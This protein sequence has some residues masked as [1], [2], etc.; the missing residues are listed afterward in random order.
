MGWTIVD[1]NDKIIKATVDG[2]P[3]SDYRDIILRDSEQIHLA[4]SLK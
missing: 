3:V 2:K 4:I 1:T